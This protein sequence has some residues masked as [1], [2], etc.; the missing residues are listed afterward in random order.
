MYDSFWDN[1]FSSFCMVVV[2][3]TLF[4]CILIYPIEQLSFAE[5]RVKFEATRRT[6]L[7]A[8]EKGQVIENAAMINSIIECNQWLAKTK[9]YNRSIFRLYIPNEVDSIQPIE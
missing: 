3:I 5:A 8:R 7:S 2:G 4:A 1:P 9:Y 6:I